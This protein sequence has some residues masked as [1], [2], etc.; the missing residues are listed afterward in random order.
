MIQSEILMLILFCRKKIQ[1]ADCI[2]QSTH[3]C[4]SLQ[5]HML[6][7]TTMVNTLSEID[8]IC[9]IDSSKYHETKTEGHGKFLFKV[10]II[11]YNTSYQFNMYVDFKC[12]VYIK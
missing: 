1:I 3:P 10:I 4:S 12:V 6:V 8:R 9:R 2:K 11:Y 7:R 5:E